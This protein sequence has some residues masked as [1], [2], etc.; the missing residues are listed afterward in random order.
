MN[1]RQEA[2]KPS[3]HLIFRFRVR[4]GA[5]ES[6]INPDS[7]GGYSGP[8]GRA[9]SQDIELRDLREIDTNIARRTLGQL[10]QLSPNSRQAVQA[11]PRM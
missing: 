11:S 10:A 8:C 1:L 7:T 2:V 5:E 6:R 4:D 9:D 3:Q